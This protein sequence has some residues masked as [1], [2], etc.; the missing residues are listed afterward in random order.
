[1]NRSPA[2]RCVI[3]ADEGEEVEEEE[4]DLNKLLFLSRLAFSVSVLIS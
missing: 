1:M 3:R 2:V 4:G